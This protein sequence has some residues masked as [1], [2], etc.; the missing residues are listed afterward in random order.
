MGLD[1]SVACRRRQG[2]KKKFWK[3]G[4]RENKSVSGKD[5]EFQPFAFFHLCCY[6]KKTC[7]Y[8]KLIK[9]A[10]SAI[11]CFQTRSWRSQHEKKHGRKKRRLETGGTS[12][13]SV[14]LGRTK[15]KDYVTQ[16]IAQPFKLN[17]VRIL[18]VYRCR[19]KKLWKK[20]YSSHSQKT[21]SW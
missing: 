2:E 3:V 9:Y 12:A 5:G 19:R 18:C 14:C 21:G 6:F 8:K 13:I 7:F 17:L 10:G 15:Q 16:R 4:K 1:V 20:Y 11:S